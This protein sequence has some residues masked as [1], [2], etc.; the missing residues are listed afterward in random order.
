MPAADQDWARGYARQALSD[1]RAR[2]ALV[3]VNADKCHRLHFLQM[4]AEK[5]CKAHLIAENGHEN[6]R[7]THACVAKILPI[8]ARQFYANINDNDRITQWEISE[9]K[10]LAREIE[11]LAPACHEGDVRNDNSEYPWEAANGTVRIPCEYNFPNI[12]DGS[13][14]IVRLIRL[15]RTASNSYA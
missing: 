13:R 7:K 4:A 9:V 1:L 2:D 12:D 6:V 14:T 15:I 5:A 8:I 10:R 11:V 3:D